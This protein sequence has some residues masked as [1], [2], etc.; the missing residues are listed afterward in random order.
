VEHLPGGKYTEVMV[1]MKAAT[2]G[3][4][5]LNKFAETCFG[6][7]AQLLRFKPDVKCLV[8]E[9][10]F[11]FGVNKTSQLLSAKIPKDSVIKMH[12]AT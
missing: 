10:Y 7:L 2:T 4:I 11:R 12:R 6:Y 8:A 5:K 1:H 3:V 9:S